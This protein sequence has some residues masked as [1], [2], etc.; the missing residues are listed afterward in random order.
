MTRPSFLS[1]TITG[2]GAR[3]T[4]RQLATM[5]QTVGFEH[6]LPKG[7]CSEYLQW[8]IRMSLL[9]IS[10]VI[11]LFDNIT[12]SLM[13]KKG[14]TIGMGVLIAMFFSKSFEK[15]GKK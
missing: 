3:Y 10:T 12:V 5:V 1:G 9:L 6:S 7:V 13:C 4:L 11:D 15:S 2:L 14:N 8:C